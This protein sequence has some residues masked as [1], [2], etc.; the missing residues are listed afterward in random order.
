MAI[1]DNALKAVIAVK[2]W[3]GNIGNKFGAHDSDAESSAD[4]YDS[5]DGS[6]DMND[7]TDTHT[8]NDSAQYDV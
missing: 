1:K 8:S 6:A 2:G 5:H 7:A 4:T 3:F